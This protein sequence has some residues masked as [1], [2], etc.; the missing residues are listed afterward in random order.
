M[1]GQILQDQAVGTIADTLATAAKCAFLVQ[2]ITGG[3]AASAGQRLFVTNK[4][5]ALGVSSF[6]VTDNTTVPVP[7]F[8]ALVCSPHSAIDVG[9]IAGAT[10]AA[11]A[12]GLY[13]I[14]ELNPLTT[15]LRRPSY[16]SLHTGI[17]FT[18]GAAVV[19]ITHRLG[20]TGANPPLVIVSPTSDPCDDI[21]VTDIPVVFHRSAFN[22]ATDTVAITMS[23]V[24]GAGF[25]NAAVTCDVMVLAPPLLGWSGCMPLHGSGTPFVPGYD[26]TATGDRAVATVIGNRRAIYRG[27]NGIVAGGLNVVHNMGGAVEIALFSL[28]AAPGLLVPYI[29]NRN[30]VTVPPNTTMEVEN[31]SGG[32]PGTIN[33]AEMLIMRSYSMLEA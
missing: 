2:D 13:N 11:D 27:V 18:A 30:V 12:T 28:T 5:F 21:G 22:N 10:R 3:G 15:F 8:D 4:A 7:A 17:A 31:V 1:F 16:R 29:S 20:L 24:D 26:Y 23:R 32:A 25:V 14:H 6:D 9:P 33:A 19:T